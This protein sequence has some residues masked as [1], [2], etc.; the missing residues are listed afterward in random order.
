MNEAA[1][2]RLRWG[3]RLQIKRRHPRRHWSPGPIPIPYVV[4]PP[5]TAC[6]ATPNWNRRSAELGMTLEQVGRALRKRWAT[7]YLGNKCA[8][9][10][11][12]R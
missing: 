2:G 10:E 8:D 3:D 5:E 12:M 9:G 11:R 7:A 4:V 1:G 6:L